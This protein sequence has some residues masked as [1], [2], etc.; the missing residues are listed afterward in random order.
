MSKQFWLVLALGPAFLG[1]AQRMQAESEPGS[2]KTYARAFAL[3][4]GVFFALFFLPVRF[5][6]I[7]AQGLF[8]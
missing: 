3:A 5:R 6:R 1:L 7:D 8:G 4:E 2:T